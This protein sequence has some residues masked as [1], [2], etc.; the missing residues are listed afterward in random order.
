MSTTSRILTGPELMSN[1]PI[2]GSRENNIQLIGMF[3]IGAVFVGSL[4]FFMWNPFGLGPEVCLYSFAALVALCIPALMFMSR[5]ASVPGQ[6]E[7]RGRFFTDR[8]VTVAPAEMRSIF[9]SQDGERTYRE[10]L[11]FTFNGVRD[12]RVSL[13]SVHGENDQLVMYDDAGRVVKP[14]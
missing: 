4:G 5:F 11:I 6:S 7:A 10:G 1:D 9:Y 8:G 12:G 3:S 2:I 13:F 14:R